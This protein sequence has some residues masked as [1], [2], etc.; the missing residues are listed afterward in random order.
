MQIKVTQSL[1]GRF[2]MA[3]FEGSVLTLP[4][5]LANEIIEAGYAEKVEVQDMEKEYA[6]PNIEKEIPEKKRGRKPN[7]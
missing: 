2:N 4:D 5:E 1:I 3:Y 7:Q 6:I